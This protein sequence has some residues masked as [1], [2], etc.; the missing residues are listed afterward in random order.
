MEIENIF[1]LTNLLIIKDQFTATLEDKIANCVHRH[2]LDCSKLCGQIYGRAANMCTAFHT[3][4][5]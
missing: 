4:L 3:T 1:R 2:M 5:T